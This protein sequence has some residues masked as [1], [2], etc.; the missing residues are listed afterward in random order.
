LAFL[1]AP[2][3]A[4]EEQPA[5]ADSAPADAVQETAQEPV[6]APQ[7]SLPPARVIGPS[8]PTF[9]QMTSASSGTSPAPAVHEVLF[10]RD[11]RFIATRGR[12]AVR[13]WSAA[14]AREVFRI[15][16]GN[17]PVSDMA[18]SP[19]GEL[20][21]TI[22]AGVV[23]VWST[24]DGR[25]LIL[26]YGLNRNVEDAVF[27]PDGR[28]LATASWSEIHL[29]STANGKEVDVLRNYAG[30]DG[31]ILDMEFSS[32]GRTLATA[33]RDR[34]IRL[35]DMTPPRKIRETLRPPFGG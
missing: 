33:C 14:S 25:E 5:S 35:W 20:L 17:D 1:A 3:G 8:A 32:D 27:S 23:H 7:S 4:Q 12:I 29:W 2:L 24:R 16:V 9:G 6:Q 34:W 22:N 26:S 31:F 10:S 11:G 19:N 28:F 15:V 13:L 21:A 18:F 30:S